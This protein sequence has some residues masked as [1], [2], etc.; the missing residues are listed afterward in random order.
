MLRP[1]PQPKPTAI[2]RLE[3]NPG[4]RPLNES[5]PVYSQGEVEPPEHLDQI[6]RK[7]WERLYPELEGN[8]LLTKADVAVFA[9]YCEAVAE[10]SKL[11]KQIEELGNTIETPNGLLATSPL[12]TQRR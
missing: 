1:G 4:K 6:A 3:G 11:S 8:G 5:E 12:V 9:A 7:E 10:W 2:K